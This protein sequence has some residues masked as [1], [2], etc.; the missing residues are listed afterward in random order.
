M[1][2]LL[3]HV[4]LIIIIIIIIIVIIITITTDLKYEILK[5][6]Q[7]EVE[8]VNIYGDIGDSDQKFEGGTWRS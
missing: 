4:L 1:I 3:R 8:K 7:N 5:C 6:S 2:P